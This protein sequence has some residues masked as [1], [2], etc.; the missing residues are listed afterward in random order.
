MTD[1]GV[2][3]FLQGYRACTVSQKR[4]YPAGAELCGFYRLERCLRW[5]IS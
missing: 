3:H 2:R 4:R 5:E 1:E